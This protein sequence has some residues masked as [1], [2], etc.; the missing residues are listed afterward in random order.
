MFVIQSSVFKIR[1]V[2]ATKQH[3]EQ[4]G[5]VG[6]YDIGRCKQYR[7]SNPNAFSLSCNVLQILR[8]E[9]LFFNFNLNTLYLVD[10][11]IK[12]SLRRNCDDS[13]DRNVSA[14]WG[15]WMHWHRLL[16]F[17]LFYFCLFYMLFFG[18]KNPIKS[19]YLSLIF[20]G[21]YKLERKRKLITGGFQ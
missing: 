17:F 11:L 5:L 4:D 8:I 1:C 2:N 19:I 10:N 7:P 3:D 9:C 12:F 21:P 18:V 20:I 14:I 13:F 6:V 15:G 16:N